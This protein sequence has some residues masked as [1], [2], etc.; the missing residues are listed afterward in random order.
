[1]F[2]DGIDEKVL[3]LVRLLEVISVVAVIIMS[4]LF[5]Q[6][7][8]AMDFQFGFI[9]ASLIFSAIG[10]EIIRSYLSRANGAA[11]NLLKNMDSVKD[12]MDLVGNSLNFVQV[13]T[14]VL[15]SSKDIIADISNNS[16]KTYET[17]EQK[18]QVSKN[19]INKILDLRQKIL[20]IAELMIEL[21]EN[22]Q[23][24]SNNIGVIEDIT[25]QTNM[26]ALNAAVEAA[27]AGENGKGFAVV[28]GEIRKLA[29]E[30]KQATGKII[31]LLGN[32]EQ[33]T[34]S[35]VLATEESSKEIQ[36]AVDLANSELQGIEEVKDILAK[37]NTLISEMLKNSN[38]SSEDINKVLVSVS[39]LNKELNNIVKD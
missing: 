13:L 23:H 32:V 22:V 6:L 35:T 17:M 16:Q 29:D 19:N 36:Q 9:F 27:R 12:N 28:A 38:K 31:S 5:I 37:N 10:F 39:K 18:H 14:S 34:S 26:L 33:T 15:D 25:E 11:R 7:Q 2:K 4:Y 1:M 8:L 20:V 30:S 24:I 21:G 3:L